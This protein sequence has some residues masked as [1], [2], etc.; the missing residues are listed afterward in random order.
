MTRTS[1]GVNAGPKLVFLAPL[2]KTARQAGTR[3]TNPEKMKA[4]LT[5]CWLYTE[6]VVTIQVVTT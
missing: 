3:F 1:F 5:R 6:I 4:E 2:L